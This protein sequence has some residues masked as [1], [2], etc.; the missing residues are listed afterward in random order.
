MTG[1]QPDLRPEHVVIVTI[2]TE[3]GGQCDELAQWI[4]RFLER[5]GFHEEI[6]GHYVKDSVSVM[7]PSEE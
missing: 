5:I 6:V 2:A 1:Q 4:A 7:R 3:R